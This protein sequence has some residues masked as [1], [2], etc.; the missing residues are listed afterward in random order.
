VT[1]P[2]EDEMRRGATAF[3]PFHHAFNLPINPEDI[4]AIVYAVLLHARSDAPLEEVY[5][6]AQELTAEHLARHAR[7]ATAMQRSLDQQR[8]AGPP[9][10]HSPGLSTDHSPESGG[11]HGPGSPA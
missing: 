1:E 4:D 7:L 8:A 3:M 2:S 9:A 6:A 11:V 10:D 5:R